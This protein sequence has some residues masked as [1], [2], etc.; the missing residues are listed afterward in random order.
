MF[1]PYIAGKPLKDKNPFFGRQ[2]IL[3]WVSN[4]LNNKSVNALVL[5]GQRRIGKTSLLFQ[6]QQ[7]MPLTDYLVVYIDLQDLSNT[8]LGEMLL[9]IAE[10][11]LNELSKR[12]GN[13][14][15]LS[16]MDDF[17]FDDKGKEFQNKFLP[18]V[19][20]TIGDDRRLVLLLDEFDI[21]EEVDEITL[22]RES[23]RRKLLPF[24]RRLLNE[25]R[26]L[27]MVFAVGRRPSDLNDDISS[28]FKTSYHKELWVLDKNSAIDLIKQSQDNQTLFYSEEVIER[29][30]ELTNGHPY[31]T[32]LLCQC[33]WDSFNNRQDKNLCDVEDVNATIAAAFDTGA[34]A[35]D[36]IWRGLQPA[37]Q[38]YAAALAEIT[39][40]EGQPISEK[41]VYEVLA[42]YA[43]RFH[44]RDIEKAPKDLEKRKVITRTVDK[45]TGEFSYYFA[46]EFFR[47]L[48]K[49]NHPLRQV[50]DELD[51]IDEL[52]DHQF[53]IARLY[54]GKQNWI[55]AKK[56][57]EDV[58]QRN[59]QH[60]GAYLSL[61]ETLL[62]LEIWTSAIEAFRKAYEL[63]PQDARLPL[64]SSLANH[65][66]RLAD[67]GDEEGALVN[68][69]ES[70]NV[71]EEEN[72]AKELR[73]SIW[74]K[75]GDKYL[76]DQDWESALTAYENV[77]AIEKIEKMTDQLTK[78]WIALGN[79]ATKHKN[80]SAAWEYLKDAKNY[81]YKMLDNNSTTVGKFMVLVIKQQID[82]FSNT[83][84]KDE[85]LF[86]TKN[87]LEL[88]NELIDLHD[89]NKI[90][91]TN[92]ELEY[93]KKIRKEAREAEVT[94][95][96]KELFNEED[97]NSYYKLISEYVNNLQFEI[98]SKNARFSR[99]PVDLDAKAIIDKQKSKVNTSAPL[100]KR[101]AQLKKTKQQTKKINLDKELVFEIDNV[102]FDLVFVPGGKAILNE[103]NNIDSD[104]A[105]LRHEV[106]VDYSFWIGKYPITVEQYSL[107]LSKTEVSSDA[108]K[109]ITFVSWVAANAYCKFLEEQL[110]KSS[111]QETYYVR[112]PNEA[113]WVRAARGDSEDMYPWGGSPITS[114]ICNYGNKSSGPNIIG[115]YSPNGDSVFGCADMGGN[116]WEWTISPYEENKFINPNN[117]DKNFTGRLV[118]KGGAWNFPHHFARC[119]SR[120]KFLPNSVYDYLGIRIIIKKY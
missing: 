107:F 8:P 19:Y 87:Y 17:K 26:Q 97:D 49:E 101:H 102:E 7:I 71:Y 120:H 20:K 11:I 118:V 116:V 62:E 44:T 46:I 81:L 12:S 33:L 45:E 69:I 16:R 58:L 57:L 95:K 18:W 66:L 61:G 21:L 93:Y 91:L 89:I 80:W 90:E 40:V 28:T 35:L 47:R 51:K 114:D 109:P 78:N 38:V 31:I 86:S 88:C 68:C 24:L 60:F 53:S 2:D 6:I 63:D 56:S 25:D 79:E 113:E 67:Q 59:P 1:N 99:L 96:I 100:L 54:I 83:T 84:D 105:D 77:G 15:I 85:I 23:S 117:Y 72:S 82:L 42:N 103:K 50:K 74:I 3:N 41:E 92:K 108:K 70:L 115:H 4:K 30:L 27:A 94:A 43:A 73:N 13:S 104:K 37:E 110:N 36:W 32:Q 10:K 48:V 64:A 55:E 5:F 76:E 9:Y 65:A 52:A 111:K 98:I 75:R 39:Q 14:L 34:Q 29:I 119:T 106:D 22:K 112:L